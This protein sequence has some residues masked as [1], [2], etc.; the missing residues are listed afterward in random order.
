[1]KGKVIIWWKAY[2]GAG[3]SNWYFTEQLFVGNK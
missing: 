1:M 2:A 3:L